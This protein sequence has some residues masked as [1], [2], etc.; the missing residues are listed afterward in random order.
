MRLA[1]CAAAA[2]AFFAADPAFAEA[3]SKDPTQ[4]PSGTYTVNENHTEV[5]FSIMHLGLTAVHGRFNTTSGTLTFDSKQPERS[6][7]SITIAATSIDTPV[8]RL[9]NGLKTVFRVQ[10]YPTAIFKSVSITRTG[11]DTGR[12]SGL[13]T[14]RDVAKPVLLDVT[15]NGGAK[16][17]M[18]STYSLG[19]HATGTI[20]RSD[21]DLNHMFWSG[22]VADE[23]Q[24]TIDAEFDEQKS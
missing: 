16:T 4:A 19:F 9:S 7:V 8:E 1:T 3:V 5:L 20:R 10:Q 13:L 22:F 18:S 24:L 2:L 15:F 14:I 21:F 11:P 23:V 6:A 12:L 17:P